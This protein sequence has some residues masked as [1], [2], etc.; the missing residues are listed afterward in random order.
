MLKSWIEQ[1]KK[2]PGHYGCTLWKYHVSSN[3]LELFVKKEFL[4]KE[5]KYRNAVISIGKVLHA[6]RI[7]MQDA[8]YQHHIQSFPNIDDPALIAAIR[9]FTPADNRSNKKSKPA[10]DTGLIVEALQNFA[11]ANQLS[12]K[13]LK[14]DQLSKF[15]LPENS[16]DYDWFALCADHDNPFI[17]LRVGYWEEFLFNCNSTLSH[18]IVSEPTV[19]SEYNLTNKRL[20]LN[21]SVGNKFVQILIGLSK[22]KANRI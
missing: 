5:E 17:W 15:T 16:C 14:E 2:E 9:I 10:A 22:E 13:A 1:L 19:V 12:L 11:A 8:G 7:K 18:K 3:M 6:L 4:Q 20:I 21:G